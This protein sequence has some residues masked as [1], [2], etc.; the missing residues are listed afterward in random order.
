MKFLFLLMLSTLFYSCSDENSYDDEDIVQQF[1][2]SFYTINPYWNTS[3]TNDSSR[4]GIVE[5][6]VNKENNVLRFSLLP[7]DFIQNKKRNEFKIKTKDTVG[8]EVE[9]SFKFLLPSS[10]FTENKESDWIIIQ[11]WHDQPPRGLMWGD[12]HMETNPPINLYIHVLP[13]KK[14][15]L[16]YAYG[17]WDKNKKDLRS[18]TYKNPLKPNTW[19][20]FENNIGW[21]MDNT[22]FSIPKINGEK[23]IPQIEDYKG[24]IFGPNMYND[25]PNYYKMGLYGNYLDKD[26]IS[27]Y[28]DD[29]KYKGYK[30]KWTAPI[31]LKKR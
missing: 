18:L 19:Y 30:Q 28:F 21:A 3:E 10:F 16:V 20:S 27:I 31:N 7:D 15:Y 9:Y 14:Y 26:S 23:L 4:Y 22:G 1:S 13:G 25:V 2:D 5:D 17:L 12:Y 8:Y 24:K 6:P 11:Q 29:F